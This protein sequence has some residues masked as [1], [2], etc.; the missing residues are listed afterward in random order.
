MH[1]QVLLITA[2]GTYDR[3]PPLVCISFGELVLSPKIGTNKRLFPLF[4]EKPL[5]WDRLRLFSYRA[6]PALSNQTA[7]AFDQLA[8]ETIK[9]L[10]RS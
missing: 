3:R 8:C 10:T 9:T 5:G 7:T 4:W 1:R 2:R 6:E